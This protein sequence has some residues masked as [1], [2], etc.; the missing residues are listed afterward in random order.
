MKRRLLVLVS[1]LG[2]MGGTLAA[3]AGVAQAYPPGK[4]MTVSAQPT[5]VAPGGDVNIVAQRVKPGCKVLF[6]L[7]SNSKTAKAK[8]TV[9]R[10]ELDAPF[11]T[12]WKTV[13]ATS[14]G[15]S[16]NETATTQVFV[17]R[18]RVDVPSNVEHGK[19]FTV[20]TGGFPANRAITIFISLRGKTVASVKT[21]TDGKG[22]AHAG[23]T[24]NVKGCYLAVAVSG[25]VA[26]ADSFRVTK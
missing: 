6:T 5:F 19:P 24:L 10:V 17:G 9:A 18:P 16:S 2:L 14:F 20:Q 23:F 26:A 11:T 21:K 3:T 13:T 25:G 8:G 1:I 4:P 15:C 12:G 22:Q 7:G